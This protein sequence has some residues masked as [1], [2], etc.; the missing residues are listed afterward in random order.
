MRV[1]RAVVSR[2]P[3]WLGALEPFPVASPWWADAEPVTNHLSELLGTPATVLRLV[4]VVGGDAPAGGLVTYHVEVGE[5]PPVDPGWQPVSADELVAI[6]AP[7]PRR[8]AYAEPGGPSVDLHWADTELGALDRPRTGIATQVKTW[9]L[10]CVHRIPTAAGP[11]WLKRVSAW[12]T[13]ESVVIAAAAAIDPGLVPTVLAADA[14]AGRTLVEHAVGEDCWSPDPLTVGQA[15]ERWVAVQ[16]ELA[17]D[18]ARRRLLAAGVPDWSLSRME[19]RL[20]TTLLGPPSAL[21]HPERG[22][23][24]DLVEGLPARLAAL[25]D[26]G[27]SDT[28]VHGDFQGGNWRSD[29]SRL[30]LMDWSDASVSHPALDLVGLLAA[31]PPDRRV[32]TLDRWAARW[33]AAVPGCDPYAAAALVE[34]LHPLQAGLLYQRFLDH[35]EPSERRYHEGDPATM[36]RAAADRAFGARTVLSSRG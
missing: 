20:T 17:T 5:L 19:E 24:G 13:P 33:R 35:I 27:L 31:L 15:V 2:G 11:A 9:N 4:D 1:V 18:A 29:G 7:D 32:A 22:I 30:V 25:A 23:L 10:S 14:G 36:V 28:L 21:P 34:P 3:V 12:Q 6:A 16:R 8:A 26:A